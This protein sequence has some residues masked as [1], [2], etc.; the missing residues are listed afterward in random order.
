MGL[1]KTK[2]FWLILLIPLSLLLTNIANRNPQMVEQLFSRGIYGVLSGL[3]GRVT[4]LFP[5]SL[6]ELLIVCTVLFS[7]YQIVRLVRIILDRSQPRKPRLIR[8]FANLSCV[9]GVTYFLFTIL[10]GLNYQRI[11][12][13]QQSGLNVQP[14]SVEELADMCSY[15]VEAA[16]Q[17]RA[18]VLEDDN[19]IMTLSAKSS[20]TLAKQAQAVYPSAAQMYPALSGYVG[21][22]KPVLASR[23]L[24]WLDLGGVYFPFTFEPNVNVD[25]PDSVIPST[26]MHEM[27]HFK[28]FMR[29]EEANFLAYVA[30]RESG[31]PDF[32]Y[33]GNLLALIHSTNALYGADKDLFWQVMDGIS[34]AVKA[35]MAYNSSYW[36]QFE[37]P[38]AQVSTVVNDTYLKVNRQSS[39]VKSYG[40]MVDL[41]L[42]EWRDGAMKQNSY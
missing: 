11:P 34:P 39:G 19:G 4:A 33:S 27:S 20:Y 28:G 2:R 41:L 29:E 35:D 36:K 22:P 6:A 23:G 24:S 42:A 30:C 5:F 3:I 32:V 25:M 21:R 1:L 13:T 18:Q 26:M 12:F 31:N 16:N 37:G 17:S 38:A 7:L 8:F 14:S 10:C 9:V 15:L 40:Q